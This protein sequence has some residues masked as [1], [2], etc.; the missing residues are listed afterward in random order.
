MKQASPSRRERR[1][2]FVTAG[3]LE[4]GHTLF[5]TRTPKQRGSWQ[6]PD[7]PHLGGWD[8]LLRVERVGPLKSV[9]TE[10]GEKGSQFQEEESVSGEMLG[11]D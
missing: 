8:Y 10:N 2:P 3:D 1:S 4:S 11:R 5:F 9:R 7:C 6:P